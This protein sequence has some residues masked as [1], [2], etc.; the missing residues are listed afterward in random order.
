[1]KRIDIFCASQASTAICMSMDQPSSSSSSAQLGGRAIDRHNPIIRDL[2]RAPRVLPNPPCTA[3]HPPPISPRP[4]N[5]LDKT[6]KLKKTKT[7]NSSSTAASNHQQK[8]SDDLHIA[9]KGKKTSFS[10]FVAP[11]SSSTS[12]SVARNVVSK[13]WP[14]DLVTPPGSSRYLLSDSVFFDGFSDFDPVPEPETSEPEKKVPALEP[15]RGGD[16]NPVHVSPPKP[17]PPMEKPSNQVVVLRVSLHCKGCAGKVR[18]HISKMEGVASFNID[19]AAKKVTIVG[20]VTPSSVLE[21]V[22]KVK[23]AQFWTAPTLA[24]PA[25]VELLKK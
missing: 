10:S 23:N 14:V 3:S 15:E 24:S 2:R 25:N 16:D 4:Y 7:K 21:S 11:S 19:F 13:S 18:K 17:P 22:S 20:D 1:M 12:L 6:K 5:L 9:Q 8:Q